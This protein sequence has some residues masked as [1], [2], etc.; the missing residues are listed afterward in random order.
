M[1]DPAVKPRDDEDPLSTS[2]KRSG[3]VV[4][5]DPLSAS[6]KRSGRA[7]E[8]STFGDKGAEDALVRSLEVAW[9]LA[10]DSAFSLC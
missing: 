1:R 7:V 4:D 10:S 6:L 2:L 5:E 9:V 8:V 3:R